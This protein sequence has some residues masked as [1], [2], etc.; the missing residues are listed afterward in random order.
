[1]R[2]KRACMACGREVAVLRATQNSGGGKGR[3]PHLC[4]HGVQCITGIAPHFGTGFNS[5]PS[6]GKHKC[7]KCNTWKRESVREDK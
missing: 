6:I 2:V 7:L 4:P 5:A 3:V 1:M